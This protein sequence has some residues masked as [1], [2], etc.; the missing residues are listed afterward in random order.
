MEYSKERITK[1]YVKFDNF[2]YKSDFSLNKDKNI[3][4]FT[5]FTGNFEFNFRDGINNILDKID[6][7]S[8][9]NSLMILFL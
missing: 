1:S 4:Y 8:Y 7:N 9:F 2:Q 5:K 6:S 3:G